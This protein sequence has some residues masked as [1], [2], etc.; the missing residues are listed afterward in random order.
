MPSC[1][2]IAFVSC[3]EG[4]RFT[5]AVDHDRSSDEAIIGGLEQPS[6][7][8]INQPGCSGRDLEIRVHG[9]ELGLG[10]RLG[11]RKAPPSGRGP[12]LRDCCT[13]FT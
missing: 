7:T 9:V 11:Q 8:S 6:C 3:T 4:T 13:K 10:R 5:R 1:R 2:P 12:S